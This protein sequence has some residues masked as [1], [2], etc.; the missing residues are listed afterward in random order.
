MKA[1][2]L[3]SFYVALLPLIIHSGSNTGSMSYSKG[4]I[5]KKIV[6]PSHQN[7]IRPPNTNVQ[8]SLGQR[9]NLG[10][11][12]V[13][14][15]IPNVR[16]SLQSSN[17]DSFDSGV[18]FERLDERLDKI[19][20]T[21][22]TINDIFKPSKFLGKGGVGVTYLGELIGSNKT[23]AM[24]FAPTVENEIENEYEIYTYLGA[25]D[26][27]TVENYGIPAVQYY[28]K[29]EDCSMIAIT[30]LDAKFNEIVKKCR[31]SGSTLRD[32]DILIICREY[33]RISKYIHSRGVCHCD[34]HLRNIMFRGNKGFVIDFNMA[35]K[36]STDDDDDC[37][38][39][40]WHKFLVELH[41]SLN[42]E[43]KIKDLKRSGLKRVLLEFQKSIDN[44][45]PIDY[46]RMYEIITEEIRNQ[47]AQEPALVSWLT[48]AQ[49]PKAIA[50]WRKKPTDIKFIK[51]ISNPY[52][53][54]FDYPEP[55][56]DYFSSS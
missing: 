15:N 35:T 3:I 21:G 25:I 32:I 8:K 28:G 44:A 7:K 52:S 4:G 20:R 22:R 40:D 43:F 2:I 55:N 17:F 11:Q 14:D 56:Y 46:D 29:W 42:I 38:K 31:K 5:A 26:N 27:S 9:K 36:V 10:K 12:L 6:L 24:K 37:R 13:L 54:Q 18:K 30:P 51:S 50:E 45:P 49:K 39:Y 19:L 41:L 23:V 48:D 47:G 33:V 53:S 16:A 34:S 1:I